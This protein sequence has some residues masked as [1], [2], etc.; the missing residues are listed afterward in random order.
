MAPAFDVVWAYNSKGTWTNRH[1]MTVN[2]K[3]DHFDRSDLLAVA[4]TYGVKRA[5]DIIDKVVE[6]V[7]SWDAIASEC[8]V[9]AK[10]RKLISATHRLELGR[11]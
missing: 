8:G 6:A 11:T 10:L 4:E 7:A 2:G 5:V 1:Q 9:D 3:R